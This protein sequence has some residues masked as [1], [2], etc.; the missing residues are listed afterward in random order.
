MYDQDV[1]S[2]VLGA[3]RAAVT[4]SAAIA[5]QM[6]RNRAP[7]SALATN[8]AERPVDAASA[9]GSLAPGEL[10]DRPIQSGKT[11]KCQPRP[12]VHSAHPDLEVSTVTERT[13]SR[14]HRAETCGTVPQRAVTRF[15]TGKSRHECG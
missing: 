7:T 5:I 2:S 13:R 14:V 3:K 6:G 8:R 9:T 15:N 4:M 1:F 12:G 11:V 10:T